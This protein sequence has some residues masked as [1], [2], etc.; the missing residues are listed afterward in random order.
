MGQ[1]GE[2]IQYHCSLITLQS[3]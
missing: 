2:Q 1:H 3:S